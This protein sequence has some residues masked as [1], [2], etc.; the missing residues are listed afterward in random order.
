IIE[1]YK[2]SDRRRIWNRGTVATLTLQHILH[3]LC[4][5]GEITQQFQRGK[6]SA[7]GAVV[8]RPTETGSDGDLPLKKRLRR[9]TAARG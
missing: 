4:D 9:Y 3:G 2:D 6:L 1:Q 7:S 5:N 8:V